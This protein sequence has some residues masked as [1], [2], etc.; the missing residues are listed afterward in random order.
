MFHNRFIYL[1]KPQGL[2]DFWLL[3]LKTV[4]PAEGGGGSVGVDVS[5]YL[6]TN[7]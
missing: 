5:I 7:V 6:A 4:G 3:L 1:V 2:T